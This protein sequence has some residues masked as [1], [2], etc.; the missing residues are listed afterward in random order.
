MRRPTLNDVAAE[1]GVSAKSVSRVINGASNI[2]PELRRRV[3][4]A[5]EKLNYVPNTLARSAEGG[6]RRHRSEWSSTA[7]PTPSSPP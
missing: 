3:E 7:S 2:S 6:D 4:A 5:V 1:A